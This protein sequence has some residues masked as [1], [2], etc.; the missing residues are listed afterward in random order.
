M[1]LQ[2]NSILYFHNTESSFRGVSLEN[3]LIIFVMLF[4]LSIFTRIF[5]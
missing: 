3:L 5:L 2:I 4:S 1:V